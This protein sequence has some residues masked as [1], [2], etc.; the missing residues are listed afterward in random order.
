MKLRESAKA[1]PRVRT[2]PGISEVEDKSESESEGSG[3][4]G[5]ETWQ[6]TVEGFVKYLVDSKLVFDF[7]ERIVD[8]SSHVSCEFLILCD[9][10]F[11]GFMVVFVD[12]VL[13]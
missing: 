8:E 12:F 6:P 7:V 1:K 5:E 13:C 9:V 2:Y 3:G 4:E 10:C 11:S